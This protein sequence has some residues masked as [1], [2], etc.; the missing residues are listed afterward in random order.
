[1]DD[2]NQSDIITVQN[3]NDDYFEDEEIQKIM[4]GTSSIIGHRKMQQDT[5]FGQFDE[6]GGIGIVCDGMGGLEG[7]EKASALAARTLAE[8]Y[9]NSVPISN[10]PAFFRREGQ[11]I[12]GIV[13]RLTDERGNDMDAGTTMVA[14]IIQDDILHFLSIG[15]SR[16]FFIRNDA[17]QPLNELHNYRLTMDR[18]MKEGSMSMAEYK[19]KGKQA[20]AL[21]SFLGMGDMALMDIKTIQLKDQDRILLCS[22]GLYR[23]LSEDVI[24]EVLNYHKF[25]M[26]MAAQALTDE[27]SRRS[28]RGQDNTSVVLIQY[29]NLSF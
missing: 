12:D 22:D 14:A 19:K 8:D 18:M 29:N 27:A 3:E 10:V 28:K 16:I 20:E 17:I 1:M 5:I 11:K 24:L 21:I 4:V 15:D 7:G 6:N 23:A 9:F 26:Q 25:D 13:S 2:M